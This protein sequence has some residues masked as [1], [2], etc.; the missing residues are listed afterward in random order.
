MPIWLLR[1]IIDFSTKSIDAKIY[2]S[3][4]IYKIIKEYLNF[5]NLMKIY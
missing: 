1:S 2:F 5:I 3:E 4:S